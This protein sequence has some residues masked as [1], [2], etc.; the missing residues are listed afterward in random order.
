[1]SK[2]LPLSVFLLKQKNSPLTLSFLEIEK[3]LNDDLPA[4]AYGHSAWWANSRTSDSHTWAHLW[5]EAG[6]EVSSLNLV[7]NN[8]EFTR[9]ESFDIESPQALEGYGLDRIILSKKRNAQLSRK[10]KINDNYTCQACGFSKE[11]NGKWIIEVHHL[12]PI[13]ITGETITSINDL[14]S[15][16][17]TCH[18]VSHTK[19][20]PYSIKE[21]KNILDV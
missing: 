2:Y 10:R 16:C 8:V 17:P 4:S 13:S 12:N 3:I 11:I 20:P 5:I 21:I 19:I 6:W 15:L 9:F 18:R 7:E 1:M 14:I